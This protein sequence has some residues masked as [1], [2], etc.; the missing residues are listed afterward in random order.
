MQNHPRNHRLM[1]CR[2]SELKSKINRFIEMDR[3]EKESEGE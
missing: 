3:E 1:S 2:E